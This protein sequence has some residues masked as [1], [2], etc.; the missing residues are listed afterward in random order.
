[1]KIRVWCNGRKRTADRPRP[2]GEKPFRR[3][4]ELYERASLTT[5]LSFGEWSVVFGDAAVAN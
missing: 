4:P 1:M 5:N 2:P 3:C